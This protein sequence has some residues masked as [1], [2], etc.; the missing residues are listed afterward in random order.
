MRTLLLMLLVACTAGG[1]SLE[2]N[3]TCGARTCTTGQLCEQMPV[4]LD[5]T[6]DYGCW[7]V[8]DGC[9]V[10]DCHGD[11]PRC[12]VDECTLCEGTNGSCSAV[13]LAGR[14]LQCPGG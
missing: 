7:T 2:G 11:C 3:L 10:F 14:V 1:T 5:G 4:A 13:Q 9:D 8:P 6:T 12:V